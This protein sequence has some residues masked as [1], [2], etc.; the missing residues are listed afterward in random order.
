M[1]IK[2]KKI[3]G[4]GVLFIVALIVIVVAVFP[5]KSKNEILASDEVFN[6]VDFKSKNLDVNGSYIDF[7]NAN[8]YLKKLQLSDDDKSA[9]IQAIEN[10]RFEKIQKPDKLLD[11]YDYIVYITLNKLYELYLDSTEKILVFANEYDNDS[12]HLY[13][14]ISNDSNLFE[15]LEDAAFPNG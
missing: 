8:K 7:E 11:D 10:S 6:D 2:N 4:I 14:K 5:F 9:I 1:I 3:Y 13:Y 15:L 12:D